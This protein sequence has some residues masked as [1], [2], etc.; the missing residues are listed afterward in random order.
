[1]GA[2]P[3]P[4]RNGSRR[5]NHDYASA[6]SDPLFLS[7]RPPHGHEP[8]RLQKKSASTRISTELPSAIPTCDVD[9]IP[10]PAR[11]S[12]PSTT[13]HR[14]CKIWR[15][16]RSA[17]NSAESSLADIVPLS[18]STVYVGGPAPC[19]RRRAYPVN[20][21]MMSCQLMA[22][23]TEHIGFGVSHKNRQS[24]LLTAVSVSPPPHVDVGTTCQSGRLAGKS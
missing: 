1:V 12:R 17:A 19:R 14:Y 20:D 3:P 2:R 7:R 11:S 24:D 4:L 13:T 5:A 8:G 15:R 23:V 18:N 16:F 21:P 6:R 22:A 9:C 10:Y